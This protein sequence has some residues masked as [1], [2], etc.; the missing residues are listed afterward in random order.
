[1]PEREIPN[2]NEIGMYLHCGLCLEEIK[3]GTAEDGENSPKH[4][5]RLEIGYTALGIQVWC[6]RHDCN[7]IHVDFDGKSPF[8]ANTERRPRSEQALGGQ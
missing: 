1:M 2:T 7:V 4:Y 5:A 3:N 8:H 6:V